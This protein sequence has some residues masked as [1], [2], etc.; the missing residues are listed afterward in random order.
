[1]FVVGEKK[2]MDLEFWIMFFGVYLRYV[3]RK[4]WGNTIID[5]S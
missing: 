1:M 5:K 4:K 3:Y 2:S